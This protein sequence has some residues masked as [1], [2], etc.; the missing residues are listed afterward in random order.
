MCSL[1]DSV[2]AFLICISILCSSWLLEAIAGLSAA[3]ISMKPSGSHSTLATHARLKSMLWS[4][5]V[6]TIELN[7][8]VEEGEEGVQGF[9]S[10]LNILRSAVQP[11]HRS[12]SL[13]DLKA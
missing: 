1:F 11:H 9:L 13:A 3:Q 12:L 7:A 2:A 10:S 6:E 5:L 4:R 8:V